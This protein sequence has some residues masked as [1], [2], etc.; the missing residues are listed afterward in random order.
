MP[1]PETT[2]QKINNFKGLPFGWHFGEGVP[3]RA[4]LAEMASFFLDA[5]SSLG[6]DR[7]N[8]FPGLNGEVQITLH[9]LE[10]TVSF[11]WELDGTVTIVKDV[12]GEIVFDEEGL[13][14]RIAL[15]KLWDFAQ[16]IQILSELSTYAT[17]M[18]KTEG[19]KARHL[20][21]LQ[22]KASP[23]SRASVQLR[24]PVQRATTSHR[25]TPV[26]QA[27]RLFTGVLRKKISPTANLSNQTA[28]QEIDATTT[29]L[30]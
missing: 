9:F 20:V 23:L 12:K 1:K 11:T 22:T 6:I 16:M 29:C 25:F 30:V 10:I 5:A 14:N 17:G 27:T 26:S 21:L 18:K 2:K 19:L 13:S 28:T 15:E 24:N 3:V 4:D 8:A 7:T